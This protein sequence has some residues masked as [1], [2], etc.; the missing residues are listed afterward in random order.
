VLTPAISSATTTY[1]NITVTEIRS[2]YDADTFKVSIPEWPDVIGKS[3]SVRI[4]GID[5]PEMRGKCQSE[6]EAARAAKQYTVEKLRS[7]EIVELRG[8]QRG[9]YFRILADVYVDGDKLGEMLVKA[10]HARV[11]AGGKR[12]GWCD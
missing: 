8:I 7:A 10:G 6:K 5:A 3:I 1:G 2:I 11:Y 4:L 9:K 12:G